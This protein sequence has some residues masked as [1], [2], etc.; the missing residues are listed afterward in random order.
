MYTGF[1]NDLNRRRFI[2]FHPPYSPQISYLNGTEQQSNYVNILNLIE[3]LRQQY[4]VF[5]SNKN[6]ISN[7]VQSAMESNCP[8]C[9]HRQEVVKSIVIMWLY[10][11]D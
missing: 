7:A 2:F 9:G 1:A 4:L 3:C 11:F 6:Y 10:I 8:E 5:L